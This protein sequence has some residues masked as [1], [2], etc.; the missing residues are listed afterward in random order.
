MVTL[1][2]V[3]VGEPGNAFRMAVGTDETVGV[4]KE[5]IQPKISK[6]AD[7]DAKDLHVCL[8]KKSDSWL[9]SNN[10]DVISMRSGAIPDEMHEVR[11]QLTYIWRVGCSYC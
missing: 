6:I 11:Q 5:A 4:L 10:P 1:Y 3:L 2:C 9:P 7:C 8:T